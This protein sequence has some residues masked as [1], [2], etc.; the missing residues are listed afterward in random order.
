M[1]KQWVLICDKYFMISLLDG[2]KTGILRAA[3]CP[4]E[5]NGTK[6]WNNCAYTVADY[7]YTLSYSNSTWRK[8][9]FC[10]YVRTDLGRKV[11]ESFGF[12]V[13]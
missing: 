12:P 13:M 3:Y 2:D 10:R 7:T 11:C 4:S 5:I 1:N 6:N 9:P 8:Y